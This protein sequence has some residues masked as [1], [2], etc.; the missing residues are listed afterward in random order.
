MAE[1]LAP[2]S[3]ALPQVSKCSQSPH[4]MHRWG[5]VFQGISEQ[6]MSG[7]LGRG[8]RAGGKTTR[9][10]GM[11]V[12]RVPG[13]HATLPPGEAQEQVKDPHG[14]TKTTCLS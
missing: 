8:Q 4:S 5:L 13:G 12:V 3:S 7:G 6:R 10:T 14:P 9:A 1:S 11:Q 2:L